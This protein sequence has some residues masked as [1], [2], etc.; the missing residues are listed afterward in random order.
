MLPDQAE[1]AM[2]LNEDEFNAELAAALESK[3]GTIEWSDRRFV[4][5]LRQ[6]HA[7]DY[8]KENIVLVGL[9]EAEI[10]LII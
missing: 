9:I 6:R 2:S 7:L 5:P 4:F 8:V 1:R 10:Y 3:L